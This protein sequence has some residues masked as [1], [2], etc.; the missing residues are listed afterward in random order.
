MVFR[1]TLSDHLKCYFPARAFNLQFSLL[2]VKIKWG[3]GHFPSFKIM[4]AYIFPRVFSSACFS[5]V[6]KFRP[7]DLMKIGLLLTRVVHL[8]TGKSTRL[9]YATFNFS[10]QDVQVTKKMPKTLKSKPWPMKSLAVYTGAM[11]FF[12]L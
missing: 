5:Q 10:E 6:P 7:S 4:H 1:E 8:V 2:P 9:K 12:V 11:I 3:Q